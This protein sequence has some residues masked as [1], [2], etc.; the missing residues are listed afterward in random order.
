MSHPQDT[1]LLSD[2]PR[3][4]AGRP[5]VKA[6]RSGTDR[7]SQFVRV[8]ETHVGRGVFARRKLKGGMVLGE[9]QGEIFPVEPDD[10]SYCME[11]PSGRVLE[12]AAPLRFLNHSCDPNCELFYW[13]DEDGSLQEDRLWLQTIRSIN[14]GDELLIDY[15]WPADA[16]IPCRCGTPDCRGWIV[17]PEEL[18]LLPR[19]EAPGALPRQTT[20]DSPAAGG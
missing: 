11:L 9:I 16:A 10:P 15:C 6:R 7:L 1:Q 17:D 19:Q 13:F 14:A 2:K 18:H 4:S 3:E 5:A 12:P 8:D 20:P